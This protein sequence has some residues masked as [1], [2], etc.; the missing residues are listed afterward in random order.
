MTL[1]A[2]ITET[3][4]TPLPRANYPSDEYPQTEWNPVIRYERCQSPANASEQLIHRRYPVLCPVCAQS[5]DT[6][7]YGHSE[8][9]LAHPSQL[10]TN[11]VDTVCANVHCDYDRP[12]P[13][14]IRATR[15]TERI[16]PFQDTNRPRYIHSER[17][18]LN[19]GLHDAV[20]D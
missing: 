12:D 10:L 5:N 16:G 7:A 15:H 17:V 18:V 1:K 9:D 6:D 20:C 3:D 4:S 13:R 14:Q 2:V 19:G 11:G 8:D